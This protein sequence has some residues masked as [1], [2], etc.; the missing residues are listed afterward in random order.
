MPDETAHSGTSGDDT[1]SVVLAS[2]HA[3]TLEV[4]R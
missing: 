3:I 4:H 1:L 2:R